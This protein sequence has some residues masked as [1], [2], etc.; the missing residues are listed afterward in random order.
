[1]NNQSQQLNELLQKY[2]LHQN[3]DVSYEQSFPMGFLKEDGKSYDFPYTYALMKGFGIFKE[4]ETYE[5]MFN[6]LNNDF[7]PFN[8]NKKNK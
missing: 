2:N 8:L 3:W 1:M 5:E 6:Y 4:Y 7:I